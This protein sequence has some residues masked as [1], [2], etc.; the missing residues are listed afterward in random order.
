MTS[1]ILIGTPEA[2]N[3]SCL[4]MASPSSK[5]SNWFY[6][7]KKSTP[8]SELLGGTPYR[9]VAEKQKTHDIKRICTR[10]YIPVRTA[11]YANWLVFND[12]IVAQEFV[13]KFPQFKTDLY[14][15]K[16]KDD[17]DELQDKVNIKLTRGAFDLSKYPPDQRRSAARRF[18]EFDDQITALAERVRYLDMAN[19][20][21]DEWSKKITNDLSLKLESVESM[22][23]N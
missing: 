21:A 9:W 10:N 18:I 23:D 3:I 1:L 11:I 4:A 7:K 13:T 16:L 2:L 22:K 19:R 17:H 6:P 8:L 20:F 14:M 12:D 15:K 5:E